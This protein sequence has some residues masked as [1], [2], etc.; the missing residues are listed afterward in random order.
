MS[1]PASPSATDR[2][3]TALAELSRLRTGAHLAIAGAGEERRRLEADRA[4]STTRTL[5][6]VI[7]RL[8]RAVR[9][10]PAG[11]DDTATQRETRPWRGAGSGATVGS[12]DR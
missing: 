7:A 5:S 9:R 8:P 12:R 10:R 6:C 3:T 4:G 11:P 2:T 1:N